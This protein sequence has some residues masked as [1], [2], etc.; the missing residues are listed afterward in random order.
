M[1]N[2]I[3]NLNQWVSPRLNIRFDLTGPKLVIYRPDGQRFLS[4]IEL[5][6]QLQSQRQQLEA[7]ATK[8]RELGIDPD[9]LT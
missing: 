2:P 4:P 8:L 6:A 5:D 7:M 9:R 3:G 1:L